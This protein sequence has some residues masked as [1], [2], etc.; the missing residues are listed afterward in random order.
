MWGA[1]ADL[2]GKYPRL[3]LSDERKLIARAK[4]GLRDSANEIILRHVGFVIFRSKK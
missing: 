4:K 2:A 3:S 1:Y